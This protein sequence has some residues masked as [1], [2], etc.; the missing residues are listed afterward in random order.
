MRGTIVHVDTVA[1]HL[2]ENHFQLV[3]DDM[4]NADRQIITCD[5]LLGSIG[6]PVDV[7]QTVASEI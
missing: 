3:T 2:V 1:L 7:V 5:V 6:C 4:L